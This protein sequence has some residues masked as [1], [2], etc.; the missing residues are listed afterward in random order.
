MDYLGGTGKKIDIF[1][2]FIR[3]AGKNG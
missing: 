3:R 1:I 2:R